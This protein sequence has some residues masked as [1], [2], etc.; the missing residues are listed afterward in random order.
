[1]SQ[2]PFVRTVGLETSGN[3][4]DRWCLFVNDRVIVVHRDGEVTLPDTNTVTSAGL[5]PAVALAIGNVGPVAYLTGTLASVDHHLPFETL[6]LRR[7]YGLL[8]EQEY[9]IIGYASQIAYWDRTTRFCPACGATT[10]RVI[11][12]WSKQ[13][14]TCSLRQYPRI[15]PAIIVLVYRLGQVLLT[16][17]PSWPPNRYSLI[18]GFVEAGESLEACLRRE[19]AEE[20][21]VRVDELRYLGSQPWPFPHQLMIGYV[22]RYAD[23]DLVIQADELDHAAWFDLDA[24]P[25]LPPP[26]SIARRIL[27]WHLGSQATPDYPFP[28]DPY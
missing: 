24:L 10:E 7:A 20:V 23:G 22:A 14:P 25:D 8:S 2:L 28:A 1:M 6:D 4:T 5:H 9:G 11:N 21:G 3:A 18:A 19:V 16:R 12:E 27:D 13:C 15:S 26:M 17:Q